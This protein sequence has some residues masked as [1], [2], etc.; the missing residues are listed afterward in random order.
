MSSL[1]DVE[2]WVKRKAAGPRRAARAHRDERIVRLIQ[3]EAR[4]HG[5][6]LAHDGRGGLDPMI[7]LRTFREAGWR[8]ENPHCPT[9]KKELDLDH[10]SGHPDE[11][12]EDPEARRD[13]RSREAAADPDPKDDAFLHCLCAACHDAVHERERAIE[14]GKEPEPMPGAR[15]AA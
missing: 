6:T 15:R 8:C 10:Q 7:A 9:P 14:Q 2:R 13:R 1:E 11:I 5:A 3:R 12:L 4:R